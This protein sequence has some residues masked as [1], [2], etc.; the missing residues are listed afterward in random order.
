M[1]HGMSLY[2]N[3]LT[4]DTSTKLR[5][6]VLERNKSLKKDDE[7]SVISN[8]NRWSFYIGANEHPVVTK[9]IRE[10]ATHKVFRQALERI[11]GKDPAIIEMT[12]ITS[13]YGAEDQFWHHDVVAEGSPAKFGRSFIPSYSLF[14]TLQDTTSA[15]GATEVCPGTYMCSNGDSERTCGDVGFQVSGSGAWEQGDAIFMNQQS[16]HRGAAHVDPNGPHRSLFIITFAPRPMD[17]RYETRLLGQGGSY[18]LRWNMW[19]HTLDDFEHSETKMRQPWTTLKALGIYKPKG[20]HWGWD[21]ISQN[22]MRLANSDT[23]FHEPEKLD[24]FVDSGG[25]HLP[26]IFTVKLMEGMTWRDYFSDTA[27]R[28]KELMGKIAIIGNGIFVSVSLVG[29]IIVR[30]IGKRSGSVRTPIK[31]VF[32]LFIRVAMYDFLVAA[33]GLVILD[34]LTRSGWARSINARTLYS[35]PFNNPQFVSDPRPIAVV[36]NTDVLLSDRLDFKN[37][38]SLTDVLDFHGGNIKFKGTVRGASKMVDHLKKD[39]VK[40]LVDT[41]IHGMKREGSRLL[42]QN[43]ASD[44]VVLDDGDATAY[45]TH[46]IMLEANPLMHALEKES[47][48]LLSSY[49]HGLRYKGAMAHEHS[50]WHINMIMTALMDNAGIPSMQL[51]SSPNLLTQEATIT[52]SSKATKSSCLRLPRRFTV[53]KRA[54]QAF[55]RTTSSLPTNATISDRGMLVLGDTVDAQYNGMYNE[56]YKGKIVGIDQG[57]IIKVE[58]ADGEQDPFLEPWHLHKFIPYAEGETLE[59]KTSKTAVFSSG[60][61]LHIYENNDVNVLT[62]KGSVRVPTSMLRRVKTFDFEVGEIVMAPFDESED[63][64]RA[65]VVKKHIDNTVDLHFHDG[66]RSEKVDPGQLQKVSRY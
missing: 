52:T 29:A 64:F 15:M 25:F 10:V 47:K 35:S 11:V 14:M 34:R 19:G 18:S 32:R 16:F 4:K 54:T 44:W 65:T 3:I 33:V 53:V 6:W 31:S 12:A 50:P 58:Y 23:G 38:A 8:E 13:A 28:C 21:W 42:L 66:D 39:E 57:T 20:S 1:T 62:S 49:K 55:E 36:Y 27:T 61:V 45:T 51:Y 26:K 40:R 59:V 46:E 37:L 17:I 22:S 24:E 48:F 43:E 56:Y 41:I 9:A 5:D 30:V 2:K 7:I 63:Y 60:K